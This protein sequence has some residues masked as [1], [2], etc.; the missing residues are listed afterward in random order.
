MVETRE[1]V[2][3]CCWCCYMYRRVSPPL[4]GEATNDAEGVE[5]DVTRVTIPPDG[6]QLHR[7][8]EG[9]GYVRA[10]GGGMAYVLVWFRRRLDV[11]FCL[12]CRHV[13]KK[14]VYSS[15]RVMSRTKKKLFDVP[16]SEYEE[17]HV[18][19]RRSLSSRPA[20]VVTT[21]FVVGFVL[22]VVC[23]IGT[24]ATR[25]MWAVTSES[26]EHDSGVVFASLSSSMRSTPS[27]VEVDAASAPPT[28]PVLRFIFS[29]DPVYALVMLFRSI[30]NRMSVNGYIHCQV[31]S[32]S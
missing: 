30:V 8:I 1:A 7:G 32:A 6:K 15:P 26:N 19:R 14:V 22:Y 31:R 25:A 11:L 3:R 10:G 24:A 23:V 20:L 29:S 21:T 2:V 12:C 17:A 28:L 5:A 27:T 13:G 16:F 18:Q 4:Q 9:V